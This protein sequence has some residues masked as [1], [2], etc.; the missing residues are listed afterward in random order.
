MTGRCETPTPRVNRPPHSEAM[1]AASVASAM[2]W[3]GWIGTMPMPSSI[4]EVATAAAAITASPSVPRAKW[5]VQAA[6]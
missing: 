3:R 1:V 4:R 5:V 6:G 2:G